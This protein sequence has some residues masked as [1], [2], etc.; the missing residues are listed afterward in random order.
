MSKKP[1]FL[2][3]PVLHTQS[4]W[5][6]GLWQHFSFQE[7]NE[8]FLPRGCRAEIHWGCLSSEGHK[9]NLQALRQAQNSRFCSTSFSLGILIVAHLENINVRWIWV[10]PWTTC[11]F[12]GQC[13]CLN[14]STEDSQAG[15]YPN[16]HSLNGLKM[17]PCTQYLG[18]TWLSGWLSAHSL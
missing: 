3:C 10:G 14:P 6:S 9:R 16:P 4:L 11:L 5:T 1:A 18:L 7:H 15:I 8:D 2:K 12:T 13:H 17:L